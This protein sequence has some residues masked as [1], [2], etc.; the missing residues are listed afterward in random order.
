LGRLDGTRAGV[1]ER[2]TL[3]VDADG[4]VES[5]RIPAGISGDAIDFMIA[6]DKSGFQKDSPRG[7]PGELSAGAA[8][9][10]RRFPHAR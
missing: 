4:L 10:A 1:G 3:F 6:R 2:Q 5:A 9:G 7:F 8:R